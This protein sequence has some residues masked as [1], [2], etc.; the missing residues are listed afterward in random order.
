MKSKDLDFP[1]NFMDIFG[2]EKEEVDDRKCYPKLV[3]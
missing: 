1:D 2:L 3:W